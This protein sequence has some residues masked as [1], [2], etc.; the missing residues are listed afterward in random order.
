VV[1]FTYGG[2]W[3]RFF[4]F[5]IDN[6]LI[7]MLS[8]AVMTAGMFFLGTSSGYPHVRPGTGQALDAILRAALLFNAGGPPARC[9]SA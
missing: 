8:M 9:A 7:Y 2:F 3:R 5:S 4:A 6:M 1:A